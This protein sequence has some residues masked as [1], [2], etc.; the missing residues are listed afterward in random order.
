M[1]GADGHTIRFLQPTQKLLSA[2]QDSGRRDGGKLKE[3]PSSTCQSS[4]K[5][6]SRVDIVKPE[7]NNHT[8][9]DRAVKFCGRQIIEG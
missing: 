1:R 4:A 8:E 7:K 6:K 9:G 3:H 2:G 5:E